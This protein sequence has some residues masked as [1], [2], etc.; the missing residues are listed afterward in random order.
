MPTA[1]AAIDA[2][3]SDPSQVDSIQ[4]QLSQAV[5]YCEKKGYA[6]V[7]VHKDDGIAG[8]VFDRRAGCG[9]SGSAA[10]GVLG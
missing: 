4:R 2:R 10:R 7:G 6:V 3:N 1:R 5:P 9:G 8:D